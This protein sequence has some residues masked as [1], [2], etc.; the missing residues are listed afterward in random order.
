MDRVDGSAL[1]K[2]WA[3]AKKEAEAVMDQTPNVA[4][5]GLQQ[6]DRCKC[7]K[8]PKKYSRMVVKVILE[9][10]RCYETWCKKVKENKA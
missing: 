2:S 6:Q 9:P 3:F 4:T 1:R 7:S 8:E 5:P 10:G